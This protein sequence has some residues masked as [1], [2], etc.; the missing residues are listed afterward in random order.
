MPVAFHCLLDFD[1]LKFN[2]KHNAD[3]TIN[4]KL[5]VVD[6]FSIINIVL[7]NKLLRALP[8]HLTLLFVR[9]IDQLPSVGPWNILSDIARIQEIIISRLT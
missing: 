7:M 2:F 5:L 3:K 9:N 8:N 4:I 1:P 6:E